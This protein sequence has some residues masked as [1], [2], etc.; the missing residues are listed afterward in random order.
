LYVLIL[1]IIIVVF[2]FRLSD[3][4]L[5]SKN[6]LFLLIGT[7]RHEKKTDEHNKF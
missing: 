5:L 7:K 6:I 2:Q 3:S 4:Q 1:Y